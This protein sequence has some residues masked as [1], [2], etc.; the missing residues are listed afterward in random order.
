[1]ADPQKRFVISSLSRE[2][3]AEQANEL[4]DSL[5]INDH[6]QPD[7]DRLTDDVCQAYC[8]E[9]ETIVIASIEHEWTADERNEKEA[10]ARYDILIA[11]SLVTG[12]ES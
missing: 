9:L 4:I 10:A 6:V 12:E 5:G 2:Q 11:I 3:I 8:D 7:D 1:M